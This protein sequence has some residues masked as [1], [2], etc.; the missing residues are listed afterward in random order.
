MKIIAATIAMLGIAIPA[1]AQC[2]GDEVIRQQ[3]AAQYQRIETLNKNKD[4]AGLI[5][6]RV[7][8]CSATNPGGSHSSCADMANY[9]KQLIGALGTVVTATSDITVLKLQGD[10]A[11]VTVAQ[12]FVR[13]QSMAGQLRNIDTSAVQDETWVKTPEGWKFQSV[14]NI[15][16][17]HWYVDGKRVDPN[18]PFDPDAAP[19]NLPITADE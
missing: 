17:R 6:M 3:I 15:H 13:T 2:T 16:A 18:K 1:S 12:H 8:D 5:A 9:S 10:S 4:A 7:S 19:Y 11:T 14:A